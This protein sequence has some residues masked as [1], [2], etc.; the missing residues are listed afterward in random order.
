[1]QRGFSANPIA[2]EAALDLHHLTQLP[3]ADRQMPPQL[4]I[5]RLLQHVRILEQLRQHTFPFTTEL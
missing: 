5:H 3:P 4:A 1:M 2:A